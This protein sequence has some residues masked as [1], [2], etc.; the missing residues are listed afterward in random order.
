MGDSLNHHRNRT[1]LELCH[2]FTYRDEETDGQTDLRYLLRVEKVAVVNTKARQQSRRYTNHQLMHSP[3]LKAVSRDWRHL[4]V[5]VSPR[6]TKAG[7]LK[8]CERKQ[9]TAPFCQ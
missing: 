7:F 3:T 5:W 4:L 8:S 1:E 9:L 2:Q 6:R